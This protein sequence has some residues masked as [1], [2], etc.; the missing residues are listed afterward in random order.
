[1]SGAENM[2]QITGPYPQRWDLIGVMEVFYHWT[3]TIIAQLC[4]FT[5]KSLNVHF[6][7]VYLNR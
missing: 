7:Q 5:T 2:E 3:V 1:M 4:K 6:K